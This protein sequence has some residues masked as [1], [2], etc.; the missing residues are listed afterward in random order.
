[1][2]DLYNTNADFKRYV[3]TYSAQSK[4][5]LE[6]TLQLKVVQLV[7]EYYRKEAEEDEHRIH[8]DNGHSSTAGGSC[9]CS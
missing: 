1:M 9:N 4:H 3:D 2:K 7:G 8:A 6:E 5:T